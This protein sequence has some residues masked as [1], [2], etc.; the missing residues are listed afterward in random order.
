MNEEE[1]DL[2][3]AGLE[4]QIWTELELMLKTHELEP[5]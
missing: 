5:N 1:G 4:G 2:W 3:H